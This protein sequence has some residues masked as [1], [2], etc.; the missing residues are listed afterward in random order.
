MPNINE[1]VINLNS[2]SFEEK[3][4]ALYFGFLSRVFS[5]IKEKNKFTYKD[6]A[7]LCK[8]SKRTVCRVLNC[9]NGVD[10]FTILN[11]IDNVKFQSMMSVENKNDLA[12]IRAFEHNYI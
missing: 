12:E 5:E 6:L 9:E 7:K 4:Y 11:I 8:I 1:T 10:L 3:R 2:I